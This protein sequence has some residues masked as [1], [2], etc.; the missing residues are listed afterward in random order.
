MAN[1]HVTSGKFAPKSYTSPQNR[2]TLLVLTCSKYYHMVE[3]HVAM[4]DSSSSSSHGKGKRL[5]LL[6]T[7]GSKRFVYTSRDALNVAAW[8]VVPRKT[9]V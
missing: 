8:G 3:W 5:V 9:F 2:V 7:G 1:H 6:A 4:V